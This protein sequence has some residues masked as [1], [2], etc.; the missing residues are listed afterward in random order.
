MS[1]TLKSCHMQSWVLVQQCSKEIEIGGQKKE[2]CS[3]PSPRVIPRGP[4]WCHRPT[5][6][7][8][9]W[10]MCSRFWYLGCKDSG[11]CTPLSTPHQDGGWVSDS[12]LAFDMDFWRTGLKCISLDSF[13]VFRLWESWPHCLVLLECSLPCHCCDRWL[14]AALRARPSPVVR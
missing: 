6:K 14:W 9:S 4:L 1:G 7:A 8:L 10:R 13:F 12:G 5:G 3:L 11:N 2:I